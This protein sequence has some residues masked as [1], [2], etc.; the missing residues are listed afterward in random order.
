ME[1]YA[2]LSKASYS[3][4]PQRTLDKYNQW[5]SNL[6][7]QP[8][9]SNRD[10]LVVQENRLNSDGQHLIISIR[11]TDKNNRQ[12][13]LYRDLINNYSIAINKNER[14]PRIIE[15]ERVINQIIHSGVTRNKIIL[16]GHSL[17]AYVAAKISKDMSIRAIVFN[18]ASS[19]ADD[20][21]DANPLLK[22]YTTNNV[23]RGIIDPLSITSVL[24][25]DYE[26]YIVK[27]K[28]EINTHSIDNFIPRS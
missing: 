26:T 6:R 21:T 10:M 11:G 17:G 25:D 4:S 12:G 20:R 1:R 7:I 8:Q 27:R 16:T 19:V 22:H 14:I 18:I 23:R 13:S 9:W 15:V 5:A 3:D 28:P 2:I 24:R